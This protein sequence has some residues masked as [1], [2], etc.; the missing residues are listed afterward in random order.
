MICCIGFAAR[1]SSHPALRVLPILALDVNLIA[2]LRL[3]AADG[4]PDWVVDGAV[5]VISLIGVCAAARLAMSA[6]A[7]RVKPPLVITFNAVVAV[8]LMM[9]LG[10]ILQPEWVKVTAIT[11]VVAFV[12]GP[13]V[14]KIIDASGVAATDAAT[15]PLPAGV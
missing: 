12:A 15:L 7:G 14:I 10:T 11:L 13:G 5:I 6:F 4:M 3:P 2:S 8:A 1:E 9:R